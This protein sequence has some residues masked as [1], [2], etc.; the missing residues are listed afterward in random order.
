MSSILLQKRANAAFLSRKLIITRLMIA[1]KDL[2]DSSIARK[3][4]HTA[5]VQLAKLLQC[6]TLH[7][8]YMCT[9]C[10][11]PEPFAQQGAPVSSSEH[12]PS[13]VVVYVSCIYPFSCQQSLWFY[14]FEF[15]QKWNHCS[16][17]LRLVCCC[18]Q[19]GRSIRWCIGNKFI[20]L[21]E[22]N[23]KLDE[24]Y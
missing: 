15:W 5:I 4:S 19:V 11:E 1:F 9:T 20:N 17:L 8:L 7:L 3:L 16:L 18:F 13:L 14:L 10:V 2:L 24:L 22:N 21:T 6:T 12:F 23:G